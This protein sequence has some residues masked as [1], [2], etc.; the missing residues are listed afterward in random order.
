MLFFVASCSP[1]YFQQGEFNSGPIDAANFSLSHKGV[2]GE[3]SVNGYRAGAGTFTEN[4]A[5]IDGGRAGY[6]SFPFTDRQLTLQDL[7]DGGTPAT[8]VYP[9][10]D[11]KTLIA[12]AFD[13][14]PPNPFP[15]SQICT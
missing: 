9:D 5:F 6:Y 15:S 10:K 2:G 12:Y 13:P 1:F 4:L 8:N 11:P 7:P 14:S 3:A